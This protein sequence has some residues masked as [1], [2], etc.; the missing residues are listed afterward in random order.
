MFHEQYTLNNTYAFYLYIYTNDNDTRKKLSVIAGV[1]ENY[2]FIGINISIFLGFSMEVDY[3]DIDKLW[4]TFP[5]L[6]MIITC[7]ILGV[8]LL[9]G[10]DPLKELIN[11]L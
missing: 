7:I 8:L 6:A 2:T 5:F 4:I 9:F 1:L 3:P 11:T 10:Q